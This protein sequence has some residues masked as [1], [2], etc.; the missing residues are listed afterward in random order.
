MIWG[1][2]LGQ[3]S[4]F[5]IWLLGVWET[6]MWWIEDPVTVQGNSFFQGLSFLLLNQVKFVL[7]SGSRIGVWGG[8][9]V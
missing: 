1:F 5:G 3:D 4:L 6:L 9:L 7:G 2:P 8:C